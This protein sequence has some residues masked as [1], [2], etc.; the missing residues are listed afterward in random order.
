M[1]EVGKEGYR[2]LIICSE[3]VKYYTGTLIEAIFVF[4]YKST[5]VPR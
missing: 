3:H 1:S 5:L 4:T 2:W